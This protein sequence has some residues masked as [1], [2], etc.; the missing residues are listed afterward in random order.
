[1]LKAKSVVP[2]EVA[3]MMRL[4]ANDNDGATLINVGEFTKAA[5]ILAKGGN[6]NYE[7]A[8]GSLEFNDTGDVTAGTYIIWKIKDGKF[9]EANTISFP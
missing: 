4:V 8:S 5:A 2:T 3:K 9:V 7:G 1:M 6:I